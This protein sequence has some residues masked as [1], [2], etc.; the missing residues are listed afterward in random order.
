MTGPVT[1]VSAGPGH[2]KTLALAD[3]AQHTTVR[4][5]WLSIEPH[6][7]SLP[8]FWSAL[9]ASLQACGAAAPGSGLADL[10]PAAG[11]GVDGAWRVIDALAQAPAPLVIVLDDLQD[12]RDGEVL[13]SVELL[14][15]HLPPAI[16]VVLSARYDPALRMRRL[17]IEGR[18]AEIRA[19]QLAFGVAEA[20]HL[21][22]AAGLELPRG[23]VERLVD[24]TRGWAAGLRLAASGLDR[25]APEEAVS[26][27]RGS[28]RPVAE[29]LMQ[30]V[31]D[32]L[33]AADRRFLLQLSV[34]DPVTADL[35]RVLTG[36][37]DAQ[38]RLERLEAGNGFIVG[39]AGGRSW[40]TWHPLFRE[41]LVHRLNVEHPGTVDDLR[42][43]AAHWLV[44]HGEFLAAIRHLTAAGDLSAIGRLLT[45]RVAPDVVTAA[46]PALVETLAPVAARAEIDPTPATLLASALCNFH[47]FDYEEMLRDAQAAE[48]AAVGAAPA[49]P[50][51]AVVVAG[52]RMAY[53]RARAAGALA[54]TSRDVLKILDQVSRH[55]VPALER[56]RAIATTNLGVGLLWDG[57][58]SAADNAFREG[59]KA[60]VRFDLGLTGLTALGHLAVLAALRGRLVQARQQAAAARTAADQHAWTREP[61]A[62]AHVIALAIVAR[63]CGH[64][65][66]AE[67]LIT[68]GTRGTNP[69]LAG[70]VAL[71]VLS[72]ESALA[73]LDLPLAD[74]RAAALA[75]PSRDGEPTVGADPGP[76]AALTSGNGRLPP[77][78]AGWIRIV[79]AELLLAHRDAAAA[80]RVLRQQADDP[81]TAARQTVV[82]ARCL[83]ALDAPDRAL[84]LI[85]RS[86]PGCADYRTVAVGARLVGAVAA[87]RL[88]QDAHAFELL[89]EAVDLAAEAGIVAPFL[90]TGE[91]IR[92]LLER[93]QTLVPRHSG[94]TAILR[95]TLPHPEARDS[96]TFG[97]TSG[98][99]DALTDRERAVMPYLATHL[100]SVEIAAEL[101][102]SVNTIKSHQQ[103]IYRKLGVSSRRAAVDRGRELGLF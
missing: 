97:A 16:H 33:S 53:A 18:L 91:P 15:D 70:R 57:E 56:Y 52:V 66:E 7:D 90:A 84:A 10:A 29:Y 68:L 42:R 89:T 102:L 67:H 12:L 22:A 40:F 9:V 50:G 81:Y 23:A 83:L 85:N 32:Q 100:K 64:P 28:D 2:G 93:H 45:D 59:E 3:W 76:R 27:L 87:Q 55:E 35:A 75:H 17:A 77:V 47:R 14:L 4:V 13:H 80:Q 61:Q 73:R 19:E 5:A 36:A 41:M 31:L 94:F 30:E 8:A 37:Q 99:G 95:K 49:W 26:E 74:R 54:Q 39:L 11:F 51:L 103:A 78:L 65:E 21:M 46:A 69:E 98:N 58:F 82:L 38:A 6:D 96:H 48:A 86:L 43:L 63:D 88:R 24:R 20:G 34:A 60:C 25:A 71:A 79:Q 44:E 62:S 92:S 101:F 1:L 72:V